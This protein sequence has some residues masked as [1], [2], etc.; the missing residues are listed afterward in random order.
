[1][2]TTIVKRPSL[3]TWIGNN[4]DRAMY[5]I[6]FQTSKISTYRNQD[7]DV[8]KKKLYSWAKFIGIREAPEASQIASLILYLKRNH[9]DLSHEEIGIAFEMALART[10]EVEIEHYQSFDALY[11]SRIVTAYKEY[12]NMVIN[13]AMV[14][15]RA[16]DVEGPKP[17]TLEEVLQENKGYSMKAFE[18][19]LM[20]GK[21]PDLGGV[22][23]EFL[24]KIGV[25]RNTTDQIKEFKRIATENYC[26][27]LKIDRETAKENEGAKFGVIL[28]RIKSGEA[29][30]SD[31]KIILMKAMKLALNY[32]F[33]DCKENRID[34][35]QKID[36]QI[37]KILQKANETKKQ[38]HTD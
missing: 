18:E 25:M 29:N 8:L 35:S 7:F 16:E 10:L 15:K 36:H 9:S 27:S 26:E 37:S 6:Y 12:R 19:F 21:F 2:K 31:K 3:T 13:T 22:V 33:E 20:K 32:F 1:M 5:E 24:V 38:E 28:E 11:L 23:A 17:K 14:K 4:Q 34:L 30:M